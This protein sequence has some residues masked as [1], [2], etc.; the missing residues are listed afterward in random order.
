MITD[1]II[2]FFINFVDAFISLVYAWLPESFATKLSTMQDSL[3]GVVNNT[4][5]LTQK[6]IALI[7]HNEVLITL[8]QIVLVAEIFMLVWKFYWFTYNKARGAGGS[9]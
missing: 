4:V 9:T 2:I 5:G 1:A 3:G 7:P 6:W 8:I